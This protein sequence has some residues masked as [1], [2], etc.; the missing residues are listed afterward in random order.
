VIPGNEKSIGRMIN[1]LMRRGAELI[2]V[3][4]RPVHVSGHPAQDELRRVIELVQPRHFVPIHGEYRQLRA[5]ARLAVDAGLPSARVLLAE[6]GDVVALSETEIRTV[7]RVHVGQVFIDATLERVDWS[8]LR[9]RRRSAGDG[10]VVPVVAVD[11]D[12]GAANGYPEIVTRGFVPGDGD[13]EGVMREARQVV[14]DSLAEASPEER[15]DEALL[16]ARIQT[17]LKRFL[18]RRTQRQP[19]IIPVIVE[20]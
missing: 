17:A 13:D 10:I 15:G 20:L 4:D 1:H 5:H 11:R 7:G 18:R 12:G 9:D 6:S 8:L 3:A 19:L 16:K 14:I 2:S